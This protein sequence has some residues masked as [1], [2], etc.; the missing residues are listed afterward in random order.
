M[1][2]HKVT[3]IFIGN[4]T[5]ALP[6]NNTQITAASIGA[7][8]IFGNDMLAL[9]PAGG[10]TISTAGA[11]SIQIFNKLANGDLKHSTSIKGTSVTGWK[12]QSYTAATRKVHAIGHNRLTATGTIEVSNSTLYKAMIRFTNDKVLYSERP[13]VLSIS[14]T[15][16]A[17]ATQSNIADQ[18]VSA[19]NNSA[20]GTGT[21]KQILAVKV[22]DGTGAYGTT[23][24]TDF[25]VEIWGLDIAQSDNEYKFKQVAFQ[26]F[27]D[28]ASGFGATTTSASIQS[29]DPGVG[30]YNLIYNQERFSTQYEGVLN[31]R[32]WP[33]PV[34]AYLASNAFFASAAI[35][36]TATITT[37]EDTVTFSAA[38]NTAATDLKAGDFIL[39]DDVAYEIKYFISTTVAVLTTV[40]AATGVG[41]SVKKKYQYDVFSI[42]YI[43][44]VTSPGANVG[45]FAK[46]LILIATPAINAGGTINAGTTMSTEGQ[47]LEDILNGWMTSTPL[48]PLA[49]AL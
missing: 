11:D 47:D 28:D 20:F 45:A 23:G 6:A 42:E 41:L 25:G 18:I 44:V 46:K 8:G 12:G 43:D 10:D 4:G 37:G 14:F 26:V 16:S 49:T 22:G 7:L 24:A 27:V 5:S 9:N 13:E 36:P 29:P 38:V 48:A 34:Q 2:T 1:N 39:I 3:Q 15:S 17:A 30:T 31:Y 19:I 33:V 21:K 35:T 40:A 32:K